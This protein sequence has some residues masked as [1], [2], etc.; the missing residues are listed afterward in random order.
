MFLIALG[1][2]SVLTGGVLAYHGDSKYRLTLQTTAG[3]LLIAG[4][5]CFGVALYPL[6]GSPLR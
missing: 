1:V 4:F 5:A 2:V 6:V 3:V